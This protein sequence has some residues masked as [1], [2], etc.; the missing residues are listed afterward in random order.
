NVK[1][2]VR[3]TAGASASAL[4]LLLIGSSTVYNAEVPDDLTIASCLQGLINSQT[5]GGLEVLN[6]GASG[7]KA[8]QQL[9]RLR[10]LE[11]RPEDIVVFYD[12]T[13]DAM[14]GVFYANFDGW[15]VGENRKHLDNLIAKNRAVIEAA[16]RYS[17]FFNWL[18][19]RSTNFLPEH[20][21]HPEKIAA[22]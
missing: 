7:V 3:L 18:Y 21:Q 4:R 12:G 16:A 19:A 15:I 2:G 6:Y 1:E 20:L 11:L 13:A 22:L 10:T 17:R 14:Q 8:S 9:E 5:G